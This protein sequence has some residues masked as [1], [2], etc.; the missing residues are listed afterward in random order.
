MR[1]LN[2]D[3]NKSKEVYDTCKDRIKQKECYSNVFNI[4]DYD[5]KP[6]RDGTWKI[7]YGY[8]E[9]MSGLYCRHCFIVDKDDRVIDPTT[10]THK[11]PPTQRAY[12]VM[13]IFDDLDD[14]LSAV[15]SEDC[16]PSLDLYFKD[17]DKAAF[18]WAKNNNLLFVG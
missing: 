10:F 17:D 18:K 11:E 1:K 4:M 9:A 7:S 8:V 3:V 14:Y 16:M 2:L 15:L 13:Y 5:P 6:F 12:Y